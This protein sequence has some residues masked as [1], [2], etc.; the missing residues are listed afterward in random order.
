MSR[1][2]GGRGGESPTGDAVAWP[3]LRMHRT[4]GRTVHI[5]IARDASRTNSSG[6]VV[7]LTRTRGHGPKAAAE[8]PGGDDAGWL[9][10]DV[11]RTG[12]EANLFGRQVD[13]VSV[14]IEAGGLDLG[15]D[16]GGRLRTSRSAVSACDLNWEDCC[17]AGCAILDAS[18]TH[19]DVAES[20]GTS[21]LEGQSAQIPSSV[22]IRGDGFE[23]ANGR[24]QN[25]PLCEDCRWHVALRLLRMHGPYRPI[26]DFSCLLSRPP[27]LP[28]RVAS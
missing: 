16:G 3:W 19:L 13:R 6:S 9:R 8:M 24:W 15:L 28:A 10:V 2:A 26:D 11:A 20:A 27:R 12:V 25:G 4:A 23:S 18:N 17:I 21:N 14:A 5:G 22:C 1:R 7:G